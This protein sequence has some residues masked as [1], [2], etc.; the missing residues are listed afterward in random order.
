[1]SSTVLDVINGAYYTAG[2][3]ARDFQG[4]EG[5]QL[6]DGLNFLNDILADKTV[7][8]DMIP[9]YSQYDSVTIPGQQTYF[10]PNLIELETLVFFLNSV[11]YQMTEIPRSLYFGTGRAENISSLPFTYHVERC[12]GGANIY[13]YFLPETSYAIQAWG[14]FRLAEV[15]INQDLSSKLATAALGQVTVTSGGTLTPGQLVINGVDLTGTYATAQLLTNAINAVPSVVASLIS[16]Q[17]TLNSN[18]PI[19]LSTSG[20]GTVTNTVT[21]Q[22]FSTLMGPINE[23]FLSIALDRFYISYLKYA[24]AVRICTEFAITIPMG[25]N[26]QLT[27]YE[28]MIS[29]RSQQLD[30]RNTC[31]STLGSN[32]TLSYAQINLSPGWVAAG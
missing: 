3:V 30:L 8:I 4:V 23:T 19:A 11:R 14:L 6:N 28:N 32:S 12:F 7:E 21:F 16:N 5:S 13:L 15:N 22:N 31:I 9:Y 20:I 25:V 18:L 2:V 10:I 27:K 1:M 26:E 29:K 24:L 17:L